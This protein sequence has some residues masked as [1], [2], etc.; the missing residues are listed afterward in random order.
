MHAGKTKFIQ[1]TLEDERFNAGERTLLLICEEGEEEY[2]LSVYPYQHVYPE[3]IDQEAVTTEELS[4]LFKKHHCERV[5]VELNGM[6]QVGP[7]YQKMPEDWQIA[8]EVMFADGTSILAYNANMRSLV[9][10]KLTGCE[11]VVFNRLAPG[12]DIMPLHKL[13]RAL[14]RRVGILYEYTDGTTQPDEIEDPL[15]FDINAPVVEI[16]DDD[17]ALWYR[18]ITEEPKKYDGKTV[19]FKGQVAR[20]KKDRDGYTDN[21]YVELTEDAMRMYAQKEVVD[22][23]ITPATEVTL[24]AARKVDPHAQLG[25]LVNV[26]IKTQAF[27]R[28][29]AQTAKQVII[30]GIRE[31]ERG[32]IFESFSSKEH[33]ILTGSVLR[34]EPNGDMTIRIGQGTDKTD[35]LLPVGEQVKTEHF[36][37]GDMIRV[38]VIEVRRSSRGP[39][40]MV[41]RTHPALVKRLFELEVPEISSGAV[42]I[43]SIA[44]E[45]GSRTKIAVHAAEENID[46]VGACV[47]ARGARV[48]AVVEELQGEKMDIVVWSEDICQFVASAL[49]PADVISV[50]QLQQG[51][52]ACR[53]IVP[54]DQLSLAIGKEGQNARLAARLTGCKID[55]KPASQAEALEEAAAE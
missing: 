10:D 4:Q 7:F 53:V 40:V 31:A 37:E 20:L 36:V 6:L 24:D 30:Q 45:P 19:R 26:E 2:D 41:S 34:F 15:P 23:V 5:V 54:D 13:A 49:S 39:Q 1:E 27:G 52:K 35:A 32:M 14:N 47:G 55:I 50:T 22:E 3:V 12:T 25:D 28:I 42:E 9:V 17:F 43:R 33:E 46:P 8:Q 21:V 51:A 16:G 11:M 18:D 38:Y 29:A 44:R 48:G